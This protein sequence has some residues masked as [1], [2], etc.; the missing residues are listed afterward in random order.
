MNVTPFHSG[1][2]LRMQGDISK[3]AFSDGA[4]VYDFHSPHNSKSVEAEV[5][6]ISTNPMFLGVEMQAYREGFGEDVRE[7]ADLCSMQGDVPIEVKVGDT[8]IFDWRKALPDTERA[9]HI[10]DELLIVNYSD[11]IARVDTTGL[12]PLNGLVFVIAAD[13]SDLL[14]AQ[15][16]SRGS[17]WK[18]IAEG[19][20]VRGWLDEIEPELGWPPLVGKTVFCDYR[21]PIAIESPLFSKYD[22]SGHRF[23]VINRHHIFAYSE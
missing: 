20:C 8:V 9:Y 1:V 5:I 13:L 14:I 3:S 12:Y 17:R 15:K 7:L 4:G 21:S 22:Y 16:E 10:S 2:L 19:V 11:L 23:H 6:A 18:V